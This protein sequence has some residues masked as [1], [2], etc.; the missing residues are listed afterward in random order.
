M[1]ITLNEEETTAY[2]KMVNE[3]TQFKLPKSKVEAIELATQV[4]K[5]EEI[6]PF[7]ANTGVSVETKDRFTW[8]PWLP[9][10]H[11]TAKNP[12]SRRNINVI[13]NAM[14]RHSVT[15]SQ[16]AGKLRN[17]GYIV[18]YKTGRIAE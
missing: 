14:P 9:L 16:V 4:I 15:R 10:L 8:K 12:P 13:L 3:L 1:I 17:I 7:V 18:D 11:A 2:F 6:K 5:T